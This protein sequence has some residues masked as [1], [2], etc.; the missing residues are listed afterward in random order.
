MKDIEVMSQKRTTET[1]KARMVNNIIQIYFQCY[2]YV[3]KRIL[4]QSYLLN[5]LVVINKNRMLSQCVPI[6]DRVSLADPW[7]LRDNPG[8]KK[9]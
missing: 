8:D 6:I 1:H 2:Q 4:N 7:K 9:Q 5:I 3:Y